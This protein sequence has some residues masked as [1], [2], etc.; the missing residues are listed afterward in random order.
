MGEHGE[1]DDGEAD[2]HVDNL[3]VIHDCD[4]NHKGNHRELMGKLCTLTGSGH[5]LKARRHLAC[6]R[7][8][9]PMDNTYNPALGKQDVYA[10]AW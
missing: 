1:G 3:N 4:R 8:H 2:H 6:M 5:V 7:T 9:M 10:V